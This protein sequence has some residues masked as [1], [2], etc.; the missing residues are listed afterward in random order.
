MGR[1]INSTVEFRQQANAIYKLVNDKSLD[2]LISL[3][4][5]ISHFVDE[6][7]L[8]TYL[9]RFQP[10]PI[11]SIAEEVSETPSI[12]LDNPKGIRDM[13]EHLIDVH[14]YQKIGYVRMREGHAEGDIRFKTYKEALKEYGLP[15]DPDL[16]VPGDYYDR[17]EAI[18]SLLY[19][20]RKVQP[21]AIV[22]SDDYMALP[23]ME[24]LQ[25]RGISIPKD[26]AIVGFD[27]IEEARY[28]DPQLTTLRQPLLEQ[29]SQAIEI[30]LAAI[31]GDTVPLKIELSPQLVIRQSC[32]CSPA[33]IAN[34]AAPQ[35]SKINEATTWAEYQ[36][37][38]LASLLEGSELADNQPIQTFLESLID[39]IQTSTSDS[40]LST[41]NRILLQSESRDEDILEWQAIISGLRPFV[42]NF[43]QS[44]PELFHAE[45]LIQ[46]SRVII[47][48]AARRNQARRRL[49][50]QELNLSFRNLSQALNTT[51][52]FDDLIDVLDQGLPE[53]GIPE[54]FISS[55]A[56][57]N[58]EA[59]RLNLILAHTQ[60]GRQELPPEGMP[61]PAMELL[62]SQYLQS[63]HRS[64]KLVQPLYFRDEQYGFVVFEA[65]SFDESIYDALAEQISSSIK[66][67]QL[68]Q[69]VEQRA[70]QLLTASEVSRAAS[71]ILEPEALIQNIVDLVKERF[72]LYYVGIFLVDENLQWAELRAGTGEAG[73][74]MLAE[75]WR[76]DVG[77]GS[78][79]GRCIESGEADIQLDIDQA[80][81][82]LRNPHLP[83]TK[84]EIALP[85]TSRGETIGALTI[86][87]TQAGAFTSEDIVVLQSMADQLAN[88]L[89]N[90]RLY[91]SLSREQMMMQALMDNFPKSIYF[92]DIE[93]RFLGVSN[94]MADNFG[95]EH[96]S[97]IIGKTDFDFFTEEHAQAAYDM[98][99]QIINTGEP[100]LNL[101]ERETWEN[102]PD[103]WVA[104]SKL[105]LNNE[106][107]EIVGTFGV[108]LN[109]TARK[110]AEIRLEQQSDQ[111]QTV[112][113]VSRAI[114]EILDPENFAPQIVELN[115]R[116]FRFILRWLVFVGR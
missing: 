3:T 102:R 110:E 84:S 87:S 49:K 108:S 15:F 115:P 28:I 13:M 41:L 44:K 40:F 9:E 12:V 103:T 62:P 77:G 116:S 78:M 106:S 47:A 69:Q 4:G 71:S 86:Q 18:V 113:E 104:T 89:L 109:I 34:A 16:V 93:S 75:N 30:V 43:L 85:L 8:E 33:S 7:G 50:I 31:Q 101:E 22:V 55:F 107:G 114:S 111:L 38:I 96:S 80:P 21:E 45:N 57:N 83:E 10:L 66:G 37:Q 39:S 36:P 94:Y 59:E 81:V 68:I 11:V 95:V 79:I 23:I 2:G 98:E 54:F 65:Q 46:Q 97:E 5:T 1:E 52:N 67:T 17:P 99:R 105:P 48:E 20:E 74:N 27:D 61:Y 64:A 91:D 92:K 35:I 32:G 53:I 100:V 19:D 24:I 51:I 60:E 25:S 72:D 42:I 90:A 56:Q 58:P 6:A 76:L 26:V 73:K 88:A 70:V 112:I 14:H 29:A 82:H 63:D